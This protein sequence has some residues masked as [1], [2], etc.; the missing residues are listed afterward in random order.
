MSSSGATTVVSDATF[1]K[2][3][4]QSSEPVFVDFDFMNG[5]KG[6]MPAWEGRLDP[7]TIKSLAVYVHGLGGGH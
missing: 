6:V 3:V 4:L 5:R 2:E 1:D 7:A